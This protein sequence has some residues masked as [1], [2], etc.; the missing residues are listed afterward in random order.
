[1]LPYDSTTDVDS[2]STGHFASSACPALWGSFGAWCRA[3]LRATQENMGASQSVLG[4]IAVRRPALSCRSSRSRRAAGDNEFL[5]LRRVD[6][7]DKGR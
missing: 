3:R 2:A 4:Y 6:F 7:S 1:M 5:E